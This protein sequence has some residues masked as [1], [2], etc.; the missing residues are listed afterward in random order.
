MG[1][2]LQILSILIALVAITVSWQIVRNTHR[3]AFHGESAW[4]KTLFEAI[5]NPRWT[6]ADLEKIHNRMNLK[7]LAFY[8]HR[9]FGTDD[10]Q[11]PS[12][13]KLRHELDRFAELDKGEKSLD[14]RIFFEIDRLLRLLN[15]S[16]R[17]TLPYSETRILRQL[18]RMKLKNDWLVFNG[19][20]K[21]FNNDEII[22]KWLP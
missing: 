1:I 20:N 11:Q 9:C 22:E 18:V 6:A 10:S 3:I 12:F 21:E 5:D 2:L 13:K 19:Q 14:L 16:D 17:E 15:E 7:I 8:E 4:R